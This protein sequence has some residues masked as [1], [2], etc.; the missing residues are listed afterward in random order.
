MPY[1]LSI[2]L[3]PPWI[4]KIDWL[5]AV[6]MS[7]CKKRTWMTTNSIIPS[8]GQPEKSQDIP[9]IID[10][11]T[12]AKGL[13]PHMQTSEKV[14]QNSAQDIVSNSGDVYGIFPGITILKFPP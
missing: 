8:T 5:I 3:H 11:H 12:V 10:L 6:L 9:H 7:L 1:Y 4:G 13:F 2:C 14:K